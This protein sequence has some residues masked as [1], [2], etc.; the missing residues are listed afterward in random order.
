[1]LLGSENAQV[2]QALAF[3]VN[4]LLR[5]HKFG[6]A[7]SFARKCVETREKI[8]PDNWL[9]FSARSLLGG[10]LLGQKKFAEAESFLKSG[11]EGIRAR[12]DEASEMRLK[13]AG[14]RLLQ[15][16]E[17]TGRSAEASE[18]KKQLPASSDEQY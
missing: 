5:E 9:T 1:M 7:E 3:L 16:Y 15:L 17:A 2:A 4:V 6:E 10:S 8:M 18:L 13:E 12:K 11:Y 14:E